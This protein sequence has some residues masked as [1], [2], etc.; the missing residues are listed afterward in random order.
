MQ[1]D[2]GWRILCFFWSHHCCSIFCVVSSCLCEADDGCVLRLCECV[3]QGFALVLVTSDISYIRL[4]CGKRRKDGWDA[5]TKD[6][7]RCFACLSTVLLLLLLYVWR[8]M[9]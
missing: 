2:F 5:N 6:S 4:D 1:W 7:W 9:I 3:L 8:N